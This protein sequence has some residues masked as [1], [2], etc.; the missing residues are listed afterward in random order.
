MSASLAAPPRL[1]P[2]QAEALKRFAAALRGGSTSELVV[3]PVGYGKTVIGVGSFEV[4]AGATRADTCLYLTPTDVLRTQVYNGVERA[5][6]VIGSTQMPIMN[7]IK[8][9]T[10]YTITLHKFSSKRLK[11]LFN[12]YNT[13]LY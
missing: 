7:G 6:S 4:A 2:G 13:N 11:L 10:Y 1:R 12:Y 5:L 8:C 9:S 3:V